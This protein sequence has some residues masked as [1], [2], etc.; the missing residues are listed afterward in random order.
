MRRRFCRRARSC[1]SSGFLDTT[2]ENKNLADAR[3]WAGGGRRSVSN[4]FIDLGYSVTLTEEQF[5]AEMAGRRAK[6]KSRNEYDFG[7]PLCWA[8]PVDAAARAQ[9]QQQGGTSSEP[10]AGA[11]VPTEPRVAGFVVRDCV[12]RVRRGRR[13]DPLRLLDSGQP[14]E[15]AYEGWMRNADGSYTLFFG[16]MNTNWLQEF[17]IPVGP[18]NR[19]EPGNPD[20]GQPTHFYPRRNPFLFTS[21]CRR[22]SAPRR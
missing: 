20:M 9:P 17:D 16:Y 18:D 2:T 7:C 10:I 22:T 15:P 6:M 5:Q 14:L 13:A 3:N 4:M 11:R 21:R 12:L 19:F 8:P 1:T